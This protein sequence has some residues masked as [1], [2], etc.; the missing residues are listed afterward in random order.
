LL[1]DSERKDGSK[2]LPVEGGGQ[3][4]E[5]EHAGV[6]ARPVRLRETVSAAMERVQHIAYASLPIPPDSGPG[7]VE[8][9][10]LIQSPYFCMSPHA[11]PTIAVDSQT[12]GQLEWMRNQMAI[13]PLAPEQNAAE[14]LMQRIQHA[15]GLP[16]QVSQQPPLKQEVGVDPQFVPRQQPGPEQEVKADPHVAQSETKEEPGPAWNAG[17]GMDFD[18]EL[19]YLPLMPRGEWQRCWSFE[20]P[21]CYPCQYVLVSAAANACRSCPVN[22]VPHELYLVT[23]P[24]RH[25]AVLR[26]VGF[27]SVCGIFMFLWR[28]ASI[29]C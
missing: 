16:N 15:R 10:K 6:A 26:N 19:T 24:T 3:S 8:D 14:W 1:R 5:R 7:H 18:G 4:Y 27:D 13:A 11:P 25:H 9:Q 29:L 23:T 28:F 12:P 17:M 22:L 2:R 20:R 21:R